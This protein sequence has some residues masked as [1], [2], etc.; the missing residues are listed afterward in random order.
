MRIEVEVSSIGPAEVVPEDTEQPSTTIEFDEIEGEHYNV[1]VV[2]HNRGLVLEL[3][4]ND[5]DELEFHG[6]TRYFLDLE[7]V[8]A[9]CAKLRREEIER[10]SRR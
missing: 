6:I 7:S 4:P 3:Y 5:E 9:S 10:N 2:S 8:I 1:Y